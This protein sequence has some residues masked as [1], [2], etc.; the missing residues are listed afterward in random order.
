[1]FY[2]GKRYRSHFAARCISEIQNHMLI[3]P[4][5]FN[6]LKS[7][8]R[9]LWF[10]VNFNNMLPCILKVGRQFGRNTS[11]NRGH[12]ALSATG[13]FRRSIEV[14]SRTS[15]TMSEESA[16]EISTRQ[17]REGSKRGKRKALQFVRVLLVHPVVPLAVVEFS[18]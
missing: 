16:P 7:I 17:K 2:I 18:R 13:H 10:L 9:R 12:S 4:H 1:M 11:R 14:A 15:S 5:R 6:P 3:H 8:R